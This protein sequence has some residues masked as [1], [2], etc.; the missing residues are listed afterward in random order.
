M[1]CWF[2]CGVL[3]LPP[4]LRLLIPTLSDGASGKPRITSASSV[5]WLEGK[6]ESSWRGAAEKLSNR[7]SPRME[8]RFSITCLLRC[9]NRPSVCPEERHH[10]GG[11]F[12][13][14]LKVSGQMVDLGFVPPLLFSLKRCCFLNSP[15]GHRTSV[16]PT[17]EKNKIKDINIFFSLLE[18]QHHALFAC[19]RPHAS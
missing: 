11:N 9:A 19:G 4:L 7:P 15:P 17:Q 12:L 3:L 13:H 18:Q 2:V 8:Y 16:S 14:Y 1:V 6:K 5:G 10:G